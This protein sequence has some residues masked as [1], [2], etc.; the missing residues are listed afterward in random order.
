MEDSSDSPLATSVLEAEDWAVVSPGLGCGD[1]TVAV[2]WQGF[3]SKLRGS[4]HTQAFFICS[5]DPRHNWDS[6]HV[7]MKQ[8]M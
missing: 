3:L 6:A 7:G 1:F 5:T 4:C 2:L 8:R